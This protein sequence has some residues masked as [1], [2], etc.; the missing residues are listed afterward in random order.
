VAYGKLTPYL[1]EA[2]KEQQ[3]QIE[4]LKQENEN[5][6]VQVAKIKKLEAILLEMQ[7]AKIKLSEE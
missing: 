7:Q 5:L 2:I 4:Q 6:K 1:V 3:A